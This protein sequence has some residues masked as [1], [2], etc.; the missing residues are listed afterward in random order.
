MTNDIKQRVLDATGFTLPD[1]YL[2]LY[3]AGRLRFG[4]SR[5]DW[6]ANWETIIATA[7]PALMCAPCMLKVEWHSIDEICSWTAPDFWKPNRFVCFASNGYGDEWVWDPDRTNDHGTPVI[8]C[9]HDDEEA[10]I[11]AGSFSDFLYRVLLEGFSQISY[12][13]RNE[14]N[15]DDD[16][17]KQYLELHV[18]TIEPHVSES[19]A[20]TLREILTRPFTDNKDGEYLYL[21]SNDEKEAILKRDLSGEVGTTFEHMSA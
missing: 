19:Q 1:A 8:F 5:E 13:E 9:P 20:A 11:F 17:Y 6:I 18:Q 2:A 15:T 3:A 14:L 16:G 21:I 4:E 10:E 7:P 12:E